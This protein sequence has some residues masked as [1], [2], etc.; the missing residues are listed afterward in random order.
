[1]AATARASSGWAPS[2]PY[3]SARIPIATAQPVDSSASMNASRQLGV[4]AEREQLLELVDHDQL[5]AR[6]VAEPT[7]SGSR[8]A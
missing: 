8:R 2:R 5:V 1:M 7:R 6:C 3:M 4:V